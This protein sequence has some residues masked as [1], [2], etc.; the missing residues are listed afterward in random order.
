LQNTTLLYLLLALLFSVFVAFFQYFYKEKKEGKIALFLF[1]LKA[2]SLFLLLLLFINPKIE[3]IKLEDIKPVL[4]VLVDNSRSISF[5]KEQNTINRFLN[6]IKTDKE[7]QEKFD[8]NFFSFGSDLKSLDSLS[9]KETETNISKAII[10][11]NSLDKAKIAPVVL[12]TDGNQTIGADY[13][14]INSEQKIYPIS[15]GDTTTYR[16][17]RISHLNVNKYSFV[18]NK[19]PVEVLLNYDGKKPVTSRFRLSKNG[20]TVFTKNINFSE[21]NNS[22]TIT[23]NL[24]FK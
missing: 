23:T 6:N 20:K 7:I 11:A 13:E 9:F 24:T 2:V 22:Q 21:E 16:D 10:T 3:S 14:F 15:F 8:T 18:K 19:F 12:L 5:F 17:L 1:S 4:N